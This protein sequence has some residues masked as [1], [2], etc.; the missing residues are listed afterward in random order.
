MT[1]PGITFET[2]RFLSAYSNDA[3]GIAHIEALA[4]LSS[5]SNGDGNNR[6]KPEAA[7]QGRQRDTKGDVGGEEQTTDRDR[8]TRQREVLTP[9][10]MRAAYRLASSN[11]FMRHGETNVSALLY[12]T[13]RKACL[14]RTTLCQRLVLRILRMFCLYFVSF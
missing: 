11:T 14:Y 9:V 6:M 2:A 8:G 13:A 3:R 7:D 1:L 10:Q 12:R 4:S 5:I